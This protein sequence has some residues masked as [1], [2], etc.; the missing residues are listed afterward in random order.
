MHDT[1]IGSPMQIEC[2]GSCEALIG[3]RC[4]TLIGSIDEAPDTITFY[5]FK[6]LKWAFLEGCDDIS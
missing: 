1:D 6:A 3:F 4:E 2:T 5:G